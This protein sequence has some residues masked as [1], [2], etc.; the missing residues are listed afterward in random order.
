MCAEGNFG[1]WNATPTPPPSFM[2]LKLQTSLHKI[3]NR[4]LI[5]GD[6]GVYLKGA[7][8]PQI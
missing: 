5:V 7:D 3:A 2:D 4:Y 8:A 1:M 6:G